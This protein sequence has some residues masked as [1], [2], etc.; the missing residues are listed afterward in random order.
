[1]TQ[2]TDQERLIEIRKIVTDKNTGHNT[3]SEV[4][5]IKICDIKS[6]R[7]WHK[8]PIKDAA[9]KGDMTMI[10]LSSDTVYIVGDNQKAHFPT[11]LIEESYDDF[12]YRLGEKVPL[13]R[14][15]VE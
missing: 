2:N 9:I 13:N 12:A 8:N 11:M 4:R 1:M 10:M 5:A 14:V 3:H 6:F 7:R 15:K